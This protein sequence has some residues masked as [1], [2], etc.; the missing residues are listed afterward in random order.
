MKANS[1]PSIFVFV[2]SL[3]LKHRWRW[4]LVL[5]GAR[6]S[7]SLFGGGGGGDGGGGDDSDGKLTDRAYTQNT[8]FEFGVPRSIPYCSHRGCLT[9]RVGSGFPGGNLV[10]SVYLFEVR[11]V[12]SH[13]RSYFLLPP[14]CKGGGSYPMHT[15]FCVVVVLL[16]ECSRSR[17]RWIDPQVAGRGK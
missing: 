5:F 17:V 7:P 12:T 11:R 14:W 2:L 13:T 4:R 3:G 16:D 6:M 9:R 15:L 8:S 1:C 10:L